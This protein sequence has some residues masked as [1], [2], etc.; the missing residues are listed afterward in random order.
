M[1]TPAY[2][3]RYIE[4]PM[5][6]KGVTIPNDDGTFDIYINDLLCDCAKEE[7]L[8]H[9]LRHIMKDHFYN[10]IMTIEQVERVANGNRA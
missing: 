9:E 4:F 3:V 2:F 7:C 5:T 8:R 1:W 10:D 6:V